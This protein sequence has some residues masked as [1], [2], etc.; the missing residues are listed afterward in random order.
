[1]FEPNV[2]SRS[3]ICAM[4]NPFESKYSV[5]SVLL[6]DCPSRLECSYSCRNFVD[7]AELKAHLVKTYRLEDV[8]IALQPDYARSESI[9]GLDAIEITEFS[10]D[11]VLLS[12]SVGRRVAVVV[13]MIATEEL[14]HEN[15]FWRPKEDYRAI[16]SCARGVYCRGV[17]DRVVD[18]MSSRGRQEVVSFFLDADGRI[19]SASG[20]AR[21]FCEKVFRGDAR[22]DGYFPYDQWRF[23][24]DALKRQRVANNTL[25]KQESLVFA[26]FE[27][28]GVV[29]CL[30]QSMGS[31]GFLLCLS[32]AD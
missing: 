17:R 15:P 5:S 3:C 14:W 28:A 24:H 23:V 4:L 29:D 10:N 19:E 9:A 1:M 8:V 22:V 13:H 27:E 30:L 21:S 11:S 31:S 18:L 25:Y 12:M 6:D 16:L 32:L 20:T 7:W 26:L 2:G